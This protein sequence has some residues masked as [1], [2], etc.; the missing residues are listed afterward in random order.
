MRKPPGAWPVTYSTA[1]NGCQTAAALQA[2]NLEWVIVHGPRL[3]EE[4][5]KGT[6][7]TGYIQPGFGAVSSTGVATFMLQSLTDA[8]HVR[9]MPVISY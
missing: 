2:S 3:S 9:A 4:P 7:R 5:A 6:H 1:A 8:T